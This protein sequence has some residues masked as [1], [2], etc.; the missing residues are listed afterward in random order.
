MSRPSDR[1]DITFKRA[2]AVPLELE[3]LLDQESDLG[4]VLAGLE[5]LIAEWRGD[6]LG[7][8]FP[9]RPQS[10]SSYAYLVRT[11]GEAAFT[12]QEMTTTVKRLQALAK[13]IYP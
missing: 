12:L 9:S 10:K 7:D 8:P 13:Q 3:R 4:S 1:R 11:M 6:F 5:S 2:E